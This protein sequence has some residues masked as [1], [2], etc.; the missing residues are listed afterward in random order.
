MA[1]N[2]PYQHI[3]RNRQQFQLVVKRFAPFSRF[4]GFEGDNRDF[5]TLENA[6]FRTGLFIT[7]DVET[8][9]ITEGPIGGTSGTRRR[10]GNAKLYADVRVRHQVLRSEPNLIRFVAHM[11]GSNPG[12]EGVFGRLVG[13]ASPN[14]DTSVDFV[15][16]IKQ[17][18]LF[19]H[20]ELKGD[21]FPN[22]EVILRDSA[23]TGLMLLRFRTPHGPTLGPAMRLPGGGSR[24]LGDFSEGIL[25][26]ENVQ[27]VGSTA[28][29]W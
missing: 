25:L 6:T 3:A 8:G 12:D 21:G 16:F 27:F 23:R 1:R 26:D 14:I 15:A 18:S 22:A 11:E 28:F 19:V 20:G 10:Q 5:S 2:E 4:S 9:R 24:Y 13:L 7:F 17:G 29:S